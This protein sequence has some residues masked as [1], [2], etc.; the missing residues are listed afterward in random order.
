MQIKLLTILL[1]ITSFT[2]F[3]QIKYENGYSIS[4]TG[5]K[6]EILI[7]N[8]GWKN[9]PTTFEYKVSE[10]SSIE[11]A[12]IETIKEF[13]SK[14][15]FKYLRKTI[16][17]DRSTENVGKL[18]NDRNP[19]FNKE[20][21]F[22]ETLVEGKATLYLYQEGNLQRFFYSVDDQ[23][24][25]QLVYK[26]YKASENKL[27]ENNYYKQQLLRELECSNISQNDFEKLHY[28][29]KNLIKIFK[30]FNSCE[31]SNFII[32]GANS[33]KGK[34]NLSIRP[35]VNFSSFSAKRADNKKSLNFE[36]ETN[37]RIG[38]E[39]EYILPFNKN[40]WSI[41]FEPT[42]QSYK[43]EQKDV[44]YAQTLTITKTTDVT[45]DYKSIEIPFGLRHYFFL[46]NDS[47]L[48][49]N[50]LIVPNLNLDSNITSSEEDSYDLEINSQTNTALGAGYKFKDKYSIEVRY[51]LNRKLLNYK[52]WDSEYKTLSIIVGYNIF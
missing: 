35:G 17:I 50:G 2:A 40:K 45:I 49:V 11:Q 18:D 43:S 26:K 1:L 28:K 14:K 16:E 10:N 44:I 4:N 37:F 27:G 19:V 47:K 20:K 12:S 21:L 8:I 7:K 33:S 31:G 29:Q 32:Y 5:E 25:K 51:Y 48:F 36:D 3:S 46:G 24:V 41:I 9:N 22:L 52:A 42:F 34:F 6:K 39:L 13:G 15:E 23:S 30:K 38:V